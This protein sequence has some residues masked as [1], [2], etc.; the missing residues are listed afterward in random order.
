MLIILHI[1]SLSYLIQHTQKIVPTYVNL[2]HEEMRTHK[3][4]IC[5]C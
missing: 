1:D 4:K 3:Y 2:V 5:L